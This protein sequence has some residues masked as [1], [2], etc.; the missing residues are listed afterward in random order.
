MAGFQT[1]SELPRGQQLHPDFGSPPVK[2]ARTRNKKG[3]KSNNDPG[4]TSC[5]TTDTTPAVA[6]DASSNNQDLNS[7]NKLDTIIERPLAPDSPIGQQ[8]D[9]TATTPTGGDGASSRKEAS[10][11]TTDLVA[12]ANNVN[13]A[14]SAAPNGSLNDEGL[15][16]GRVKKVNKGQ[17]NT[18]AKMLSALRR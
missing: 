9:A 6:T 5:I 11:S 10:T 2:K 16:G 1:L 12:A 14:N 15:G 13:A 8:G 17:I 18:L 3:N 7:N 4:A